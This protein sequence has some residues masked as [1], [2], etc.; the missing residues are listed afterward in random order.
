VLHGELQVPKHMDTYK[1]DFGGN[2]QSIIEFIYRYMDNPEIEY[3]QAIE[4]V[5]EKRSMVII[6]I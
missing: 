5:C 3:V 2:D 6:P 1:G 4:E